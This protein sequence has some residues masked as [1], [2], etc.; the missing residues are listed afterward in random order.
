[1]NSFSELFGSMGISA[2]GM[3]V[4][5]RRLEAS[6][7]N[8]S[9]VHIAA[10]PGQETAQVRSVRVREKGTMDTEDAQFSE[11]MNGHRIQGVAGENIDAK[12]PSRLQYEPGNPVADESGMV[13]YPAVDY[14][15]EMTSMMQ[16]SRAFEANVTAYT[17]ARNMIQR[18]LEIG[19]GA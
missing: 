14:L 4:E 19:R 11:F 17:E 8:L 7:R 12:A 2:T 3:N 6:A 18:A 15:T 1:M 10:R 5:Q 9:I 16:S 13:A